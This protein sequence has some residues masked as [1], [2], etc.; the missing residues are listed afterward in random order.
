LQGAALRALLAAAV[1]SALLL[2]G[3]GGGGED[4]SSSTASTQADTT[5]TANLPEAK[6]EELRRRLEQLKEEQRQEQGADSKP[7]SQGS[8][9]DQQPDTAPAPPVEHHDSGG[10]AAQFKTKSADNSIQEF[11][12]EASDSE[13]DRAAEVLHGFLD[14]RAARDWQ[15]ACSY[16]S[17]GLTGSLEALVARAPQGEKPEGC[18]EIL[19][20]LSAGVP[21]QALKGVAK[22]D[23]G[24]LRSEGD[25]GFL[26]YHGA[27]GEDYAMPMAIEGGAWKVGALEGSPL[28]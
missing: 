6:K 5:A 15:G 21:D 2:A 7:P 17:A 27:H 24:S 26:L 4:G 18:A 20:A 11:G 19:A 16:M 8:G 25:R 22:A 28:L 3:C 9:A 10:G 1:V 14:A 13:R 12:S 23:V